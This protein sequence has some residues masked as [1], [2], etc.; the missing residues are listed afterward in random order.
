M[1]RRSLIINGVVAMAGMAIPVFGQVKKS[2]PLPKPAPPPR[3]TFIPKSA[4]R[5]RPEKVRDPVC[6]LMVEKDPELSAVYKGQ[7]YYFCS[8]ADRD[9][10]KKNP[11]KY[12]KGK[13]R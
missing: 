7:T 10:F 1:K 8:K 4:P 11:E 3:S 9:K 13:R 5:P 6:G 12:V 2:D